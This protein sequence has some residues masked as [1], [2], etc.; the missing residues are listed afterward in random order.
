M[1]NIE[2]KELEILKK[3]IEMDDIQKFQEY[4][5]D[6]DVNDFK[7]AFLPNDN[8]VTSRCISILS[9]AL[10][11]SAAK[12]SQY[13]IEKNFFLNE[14]ERLYSVYSGDIKIMHLVTEN[15]PLPCRAIEVA[16]NRG[17]KSMLEFLI[18]NARSSS[19]KS[20]EELVIIAYNSLTEEY[21]IERLQIFVYLLGKC[22]DHC[23]FSIILYKAT[24]KQEIDVI[25]ALLSKGYFSGVEDAYCFAVRNS[26]SSII[27]IFNSYDLNID[28][29]QIQDLLHSEEIKLSHNDYLKTSY[30]GFTENINLSN[31]K[32]NNCYIKSSDRFIYKY[33][34]N[35]NFNKASLLKDFTYSEFLNFLIL[36]QNGEWNHSSLILAK[37]IDK[38]QKGYYTS[39]VSLYDQTIKKYTNVF[40]IRVYKDIQRINI[41]CYRPYMLKYKIEQENGIEIYRILPKFT[42]NELRE[43]KTNKNLIYES[44]SAF[45]SLIKSIYW[46]IDEKPDYILDALYSHSTRVIAN[47]SQVTLNKE[48]F[49]EKGGC[50]V[51]TTTSKINCSLRFEDKRVYSLVYIDSRANYV[52]NDCNYIELDC[53]FYSLRPYTVCIPFAIICNESLPLGI[54][55]GTTEKSTIFSEFYNLLIKVYPD[56]NIAQKPVLSDEGSALKC[57]VRTFGEENKKIIHFFCFRHILEKFGSGTLLGGAIK[58][59]IFSYSKEEFMKNWC[60]Q[61]AIIESELARFP[62][63]IEAF[64]T[65]FKC[66]YSKGKLSTP[67]IDE[68]DQLIWN[69]KKYCVATC[70]NHCEG[71]HAKFNSECREFRK[72][73]KRFDILMKHINMRYETY[74]N[75]RNLN[76]KILEYRNIFNEFDEDKKSLYANSICTS[77]ICKS[78]IEFYTALYGVPFT[79]PH[80]IQNYNFTFPKLPTYTK[81]KGLKFFQVIDCQASI[82]VII[83]Y[84]TPSLTSIKKERKEPSLHYNDDISIKE[85]THM[86]NFKIFAV[87]LKNKNEK[88]NFIT[89]PVKIIDSDNPNFFNAK[90]P[91]LIIDKKNE[92]IEVMIP[93]NLKINFEEYKIDGCLLSNEKNESQHFKVKFYC[94]TVNYPAE[95]PNSIKG[96]CGYKIC[97]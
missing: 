83:P 11:V 19:S 4:F 36:L 9:L 90:F 69:R 97:I 66:T 1:A 64:K 89:A 23:D 73:E 56:I 63:K 26:Y 6:K 59:L 49:E 15:K 35:H 8:I 31:L 68:I 38:K 72:V 57:F 54:S 25:S 87:I 10:S 34:L 20:N 48:Y 65:F 43:Q 27:D 12:I 30:I 2:K 92:E 16:I 46:G 44:L 33:P 5:I 58:A 29:E 77:P 40:L 91:K 71:S 22:D 47:P 82:K 79:C 62:D 84:N 24:Q 53:T 76:A 86:M 81:T 61:K 70:S 74:Q 13:L 80:N 60:K 51:V 45:E 67:N 18:E 94:Y 88:G 7:I 50:L 28:K 21:S 39:S 93:Y 96:I 17:V 52:I 3:I 14:Q 42:E 85:T 75:C 41:L 37:D 95:D 32:V 55:L 78:R